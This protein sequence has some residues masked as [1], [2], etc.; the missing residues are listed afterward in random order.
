MP[1]VPDAPPLQAPPAPEAPPRPPA[2]LAPALP[3]APPRP[4][5]AVEP[6]EPEVPPRPRPG[7][8]RRGARPPVPVVPPGAVVPPVAPPEPA[9]PPPAPA[10]PD[11]VAPPLPALA[12]PPVRPF[13]FGHRWR[14]RPR[15]TRGPPCPPWV[16]RSRGPGRGRWS[17]GPDRD[18]EAGRGGAT[19]HGRRMSRAG[20]MITG[21]N[22]RAIRRAAIE[23][24]QERR[25]PRQPCRIGDTPADG[26]VG[27]AR[28]SR[29]LR[30]KTSPLPIG[31]NSSRSSR[32]WSG[33]NPS[34]ASSTSW[35]ARRASQ[36]W[37]IPPRSCTTLENGSGAAL[38]GA[39]SRRMR[40]WNRLCGKRFRRSC[41][42]LAN[43]LTD[44]ASLGSA[45]GTE[46]V[47]YLKA[48]GAS[49]GAPAIIEAI[50]DQS[51]STLWSIG[52]LYSTFTLVRVAAAPVDGPFEA[53][54]RKWCGES[55]SRRAMVQAAFAGNAANR[56]NCAR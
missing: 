20:E 56:E 27:S 40:K 37:R 36:R 38:R 43:E 18:E 31:P 5:E 32:R 2:P 14:C 52:T 25:L 4:P 39:R 33:K 53:R 17:K 24:A 48:C 26:G 55:R 49:I 29:F 22:G 46:F 12:L 16:R 47:T 50:K 34:R 8:S 13:R 1:P 28:W 21:K 7:G 30:Q 15:P 51:V 11:A 41:S 23:L 45:D 19:G 35:E 54:V 10:P 44:P 42:R 6:P 9:A 3:A